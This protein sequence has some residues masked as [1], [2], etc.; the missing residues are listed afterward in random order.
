VKQPLSWQDTSTNPTNRETMNSAEWYGA[1]LGLLLAVWIIYRITSRLIRLL[2][3]GASFFLLKHLFYAKGI[4]RGA[5]WSSVSR[6]QMLA[7]VIYVVANAICM[8]WG[9][10]SVAQFSSRAAFLSITN[11]V[12]LFAGS[13]LSLAADALGISLRTQIRMHTWMGLMSSV[14]AVLHAVLS[15]IHSSIDRWDEFTISGITVSTPG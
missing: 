12:P 3:V 1:G 4:G 5:W 15:V 2:M 13:Q 7:V 8:A 6:F 9:Y 10:K 14:Q 11:L